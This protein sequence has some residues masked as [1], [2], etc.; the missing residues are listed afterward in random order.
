MTTQEVLKAPF[1]YFGGKSAAAKDVWRAL[2]RVNNF[3]EPFFGSGAVLLA[4]PVETWATPDAPGTE[5]VN[6]KSRFLA[7]FWRAVSH[8]PDE[9][10]AGCDW[11]VNEADLHARHK[12]LVKRLPELAALLDGDP[13]AFDAKVAAWWCWGQCAWIGS[14]WC[15]EARADVREQLPHVG[16]AG[17]GIHR[18][19]PHV[20]GNHDSGRGVHSRGRSGGLF[21]YF[22]AL[23]ARLRRVRV[24]CGDWSRV[25]GDSVTWRHGVTGVFLDPPYL[26]GAVQ[27]AAGGA[28]TSLSADVRA[29]AIE[30]GKRRDM[31]VVLAG[32]EGE[33]TMPSDWR[34]VAWKARGGYGSQRKDGTTNENARR[35]RLYLSPHCVEQP[36]RQP[37]LFDLGGGAK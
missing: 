29:W 9:V 11:P 27:Y 13:E 34:V 3:V 36:P 16:N 30:A 14:G 1:I 12:W 18:K 20:G 5:T 21:D 10:A 2:G 17:Q 24:A 35:E 19:L 4:R 8:A 33:H 23:S 25:M 32:Y 28:G 15:D 26:D 37:S 31:R 6:D 22:A 7:N